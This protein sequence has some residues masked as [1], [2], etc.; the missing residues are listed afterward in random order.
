MQQVVNE[1]HIDLL[2]EDGQLVSVALDNIK[3]GNAVAECGPRSQG[4]KNE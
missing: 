4:G 3:K 1:Q 2:L